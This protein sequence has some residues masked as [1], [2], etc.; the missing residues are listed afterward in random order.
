MTEKDEE[1]RNRYD[2]SF[3][4]KKYEN[5]WAELT[6]KDL[7]GLFDQIADLKAENERA[8]NL[9]ECYR[10][11]FLSC[12]NEWRSK[13]EKAIETKFQSFENDDECCL[14]LLEELKKELLSAEKDGFHK[15]ADISSCDVIS[16]TERPSETD[17]EGGDE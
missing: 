4:T 2:K 10:E 11:N 16:N 8:N 7:K 1:I 15:G 5:D 6:F 12:D 14:I 9:I 13:I 17:E 3:F